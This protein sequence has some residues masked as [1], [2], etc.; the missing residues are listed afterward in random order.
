MVLVVVAAVKC[1]V[2][3]SSVDE[4]DRMSGSWASSFISICKAGLKFLWSGSDRIICISNRQVSFDC[5]VRG[6]DVQSYKVRANFWAP[7]GLQRYLIYPGIFQTPPKVLT[8]T[9]LPQKEAQYC[10]SAHCRGINT[11]MRKRPLAYASAN[12]TFSHSNGRQRTIVTIVN[13][14]TT[15]SPPIFTLDRPSIP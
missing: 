14:D 5:D 9:T 15:Y 10:R 11:R 4:A 2:G 8:V 7:W 6:G 13:L 12:S 3:S 1:C